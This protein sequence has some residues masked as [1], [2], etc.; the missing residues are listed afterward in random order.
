MTELLI[1]SNRERSTGTA[2]Q[3]GG[4]LNSSVLR[5]NSCSKT[6]QKM[7]KPG[8]QNAPT[9]D[10]EKPEELG[11]F[12]GRI[13]EWFFEKSIEA[14]KERKRCIVKYLDAVLCLD[15]KER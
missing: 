11:R 9:F 7:P 6:S 8:E 14:D 12:F 15:L 3:T 13:E 4:D 5:E 1:G 2:A 10:T